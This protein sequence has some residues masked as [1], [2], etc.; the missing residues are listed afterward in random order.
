MSLE[1][2]VLRLQKEEHPSGAEKALQG[3][4]SALANVYGR[5]VRARRTKDMARAVQ[6]GVPVISVGNITA[7]GTGKTP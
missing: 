6:A 3:G 7:G 2:Y 5:G 1:S 4:L